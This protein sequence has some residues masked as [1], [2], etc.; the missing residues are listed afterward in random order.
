VKPRVLFVSGTRYAL[1]LEG[2]MARKWEALAGELD[3]RVLAR[4]RDGNDPRFALELPENGILWRVSLFRHVARQLR[5]FQPDAV[6]TEGPVEAASCLRARKL[7]GSHVPVVTDIH[8]DWRTAT[9]LYGSRLRHVLSWTAERVSTRALREVD[10][11]RT[12]S[13]FTSDLVREVGVEPL[14]EFPA[15]IDLSGFEG[16]RVELPAQP[17]AAFVGVLERYKGLSTLIATWDLVRAQ[18]PEARLAMVG[19]GHAEAEV[20]R[21][22][23]RSEGSVTWVERLDNTEVAAFLDASTCLFLPSESEGL[24]RIVMEAFCRGRPVV[25]TRAGGVPDLVRDGENGYVLERG[26]AEGL[27]AALVRVLGDPA[28]ARRLAAGAAASD[29]PWRATPEDFATR[30]RAVVEA[31]LARRE[32]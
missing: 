32:P 14:A 30:T 4:G 2:A 23:E 15:F 11:V 31:V 9:R 26:D 16:P 20:R 28:E 7:V 10:G 17:R 12:L 19:A 13:P 3:L 24:P 21:F 18:L 25:A 5:A 27:A 6:L 8:G 22:V 1:P 29:G